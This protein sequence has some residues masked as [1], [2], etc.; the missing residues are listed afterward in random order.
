MKRFD[1]PLFLLFRIPLIIL[2]AAILVIG[3]ATVVSAGGPAVFSAAAPA[4]GSTE[5]VWKPDISVFVDDAVQLNSSTVAMKINGQTVTCSLSYRVSGQHPEEVWDDWVGS[6]T[7]WVTDYDNTA[8]TISYKPTTGL[9]EGNNTVEVSVT[10]VNGETSTY[11]W[12]FNVQLPEAAFSSTTPAPNSNISVWNPD[13]SVSVDDTANIQTYVMKINGEPV[14][15]SLSLKDLGGYWDMEGYYP[16]YD[17]TAGTISYT[18]AMLTDGL[19]TVDILVTN[20]NGKTS[21][22]TWSFDVKAPPQLSEASPNSDTI[23]SADMPTISAKVT[24]NLSGISGIKMLLDGVEV[25]AVFDPASNNVRFTPST[26]LSKDDFDHFVKLTVTDGTGLSS[27]LN[28][29]ILNRSCES[30]H[31]GYPASFMAPQKPHPTDNCTA[32]HGGPVQDCANCHYNNSN[33]PGVKHG[34]EYISTSVP[35]WYDPLSCIQCHNS[36]YGNIPKHPAD[37]ANYHN[38]TSS[39][40]TCNKCHLS[41]LSKEHARRTD[42][43]GKNYDCNTCHSSTNTVVL[44]AIANKQK[45]CDA[46]HGS[47]VNH[48]D[49]HNTT[50][51]DGNC[52]TCHNNSLTQEHLSNQKTQTKTLNCDTCHNNSG[53]LVSGAIAT[54]N[55]Q[56][57]ACHRQG[58][59]VNFTEN[60]PADIPLYSGFKWTTPINAAVFAGENWVPGEFVVGGKVILSNRRTDVSG[61]NVFAFYSNQL[62]GNGWALASDGPAPGANFYSVTFTKGIHKAVIWFYGGEDHN[63]SPVSPGGYRV[64]ILYK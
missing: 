18:P 60:I 36:A 24:E 13:I 46:C 9:P 27:S 54:D 38:T 26:P 58:H 48:E 39:M 55:K 11:S 31:I 23:I 42:A 57:A 37:N 45:N 28:W 16:Y 34:P 47:N 29:S 56:C 19:K 43:N 32:C 7:I 62:V 50:N 10:N 4:P 5:N 33:P 12:S 40:D 53:A 17:Y 15:A 20:A 3:L 35:G 51:L 14:N 44:Q 22:Y 49:L 2:F 30:C 61:D 52:T 1:K 25:P 41:S 6:Y 8:G 21:T 64:E 59:N 63:V